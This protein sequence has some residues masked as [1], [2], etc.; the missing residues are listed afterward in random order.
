MKTSYAIVVLLLLTV[1]LPVL[2]DPV[3]VTHWEFQAVY[4][5]GTS[6]FDD[7]GPTEVV[8]EGI[9]LNNPEDWVD[10]TPD[11]TPGMWQMGGEWEIFVQG[12]GGDHAGTFCWMGQNYGNGPGSDNYTNEEWLSEICKLNRDPD[13]GYIFRIGDR[14]RVTGRYLFY[15]GKLNINENHYIE[16]AFDFKVELVEP[17]V[18]LPQPEPIF[19]SDLK[20]SNDNE[21]FDSARLTGGEYY[22]GQLVRIQDVNIADPQNWGLDSQVEILDANGLT[23]PVVLCRGA[24]LSRYDCPTGQIDVIGILDQKSPGSPP[25]FDH[26]KGYRLLVMDYD[27]N[28]LVVGNTGRPRGNLPGDINGDYKVDLTDFAE[29]SANWLKHT[30]GLYDCP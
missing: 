25:I 1:S 11:P 3:P 12:E 26:T 10:P 30:S 4:S 18:G 27:G 9:L 19:I 20:D 14:V 22:Q 28:G 5:D 6:S 13:T 24:G 21:I 7:S 29:L 16:E 8:I 23:F 2:G 15:K 17:A